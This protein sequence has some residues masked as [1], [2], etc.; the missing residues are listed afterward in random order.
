MRAS[1]VVILIGLLTSGCGGGGGGSSSPSPSS[2]DTGGGGQYGGGEDD[3]FQVSSIVPADGTELNSFPSEIVVTF[4]GTPSAVSITASS[5]TVIQ[6]GGDDDFANGNETEVSWGSVDVS[7]ATATFD[8]SGT[9]LNDDSYRVTL[10]GNGD[11]VVSSSAGDVL[12]GNGNGNA[13]GNYNSDFAVM[14]AAPSGATFSAI[15]SNIF[16]VSCALSGCHTGGSPTGGMNLS[17]GM[18]YTNIVGV[19]SSEVPG[20]QRINPGN[21]DDSYMVQ[22]LEGTAAVGAQMPFGS[23]PLSTASIQ[24]LRD[25]IEAGAMDN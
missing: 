24:N 25:W 13:G 1:I 5:V 4:N 7:A 18:A 21:A 22:K 17:E 9:N 19:A 23:A 6:S 11:D 2:G 10:R 16:N 12:D 8:F 3:S 20:L 15:Q 14:A